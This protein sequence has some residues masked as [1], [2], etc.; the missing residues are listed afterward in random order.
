MNGCKDITLNH[1][2]KEGGI[3]GSEIVKISN[4]AANSRFTYMLF[5]A[6]NS[7]VGPSLSTSEASM[8][9]T[10]GSF[11]MLE[12]MPSFEDDTIAGSKCWFAGCFEIVG[13]S[14]NYV[15]DKLSR[16]S[17]HIN[18]KLYCDNLFKEKI[19]SN[20]TGAFL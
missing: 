20:T 5:A 15:V 19:R 7:V 14:F 13:D 18:E 9:F 12:E 3:N 1:N 2:I 6:D 16:E 4:V 11:A 17:P 10:D 8:T